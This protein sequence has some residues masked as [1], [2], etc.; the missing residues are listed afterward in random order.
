MLVR[1][2]RFGRHHYVDIVE[3]RRW[4]GKKRCRILLSLGKC[5][6]RARQQEIREII[7]DYQPLEH[8]KLVLEELNNASGPWQG[9]GYFKKMHFLR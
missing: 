5:D 9:K 6:D 4:G 8:A 7:R 2:S 1:I 3:Y